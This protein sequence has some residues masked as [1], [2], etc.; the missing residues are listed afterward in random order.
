VIR[1]DAY[2]L[3]DDWRVTLNPARRLP[4]APVARLDPRFYRLI[5][6]LETRFPDGPPS[7]V[8]CEQLTVQGDVRFGRGVVCRGAATVSNAGPAQ[9]TIA[10][11]AV[12]EGT[13]IL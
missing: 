7:L 8:D 12:L 5:D 9:A 1:S 6:D 2:V 10:D 3:T 11:G 4:K 13:H